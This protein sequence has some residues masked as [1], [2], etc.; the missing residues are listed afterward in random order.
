MRDFKGEVRAAIVLGI[1]TVSQGSSSTTILPGDTIRSGDTLKL[2]PHYETNWSNKWELGHI[3]ATKDSIFRNIKTINELE[4]I[5][6]YQKNRWIFFNSP[7]LEVKVKNLNPNTVTQELRSFN[8]K[9]ETNR[10]SLGASGGVMWIPG[11]N[12]K[13]YIG[14]GIN[15]DIIRFKKWRKR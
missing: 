7:D 12:P 9:N 14:I 8:V 5:T 4:I 2:Y 11:L 10:F 15:Y 1:N 3:K 6:G 13:P